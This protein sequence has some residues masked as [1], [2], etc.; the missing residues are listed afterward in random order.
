LLSAANEGRPVVTDADRL[1]IV[2]VVVNAGT[3]TG[4]LVVVAVRFRWTLPETPPL[5][6]FL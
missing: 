4:A 3:V 1:V 5:M 6:F 2:V